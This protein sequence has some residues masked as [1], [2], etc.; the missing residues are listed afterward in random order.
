MLETGLDGV[1]IIEPVV[2]G[3]DRGFFLEN[4]KA[5]S[6]RA[7]GLPA[8]FSQSNVSRSARGVLRGLHFQFRKCQ[9]KL[10]SVFEGCIFDV[11]VDVRRGSTSF[12]QWVGTQLSADN[13]RQL[14]IPA[15]FAHGFL[16]LSEGAL[17][18]YLCTTEY[19]PEYDAAVAWDDPA[20]GVKWPHTP[21]ALSA[22]D[23]NAPLLKD[24]PSERLPYAEI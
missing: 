8:A 4:W 12:G 16:V 23:R 21:T 19:A 7:H 15:G 2:H 11:A 22:R 5:S 17:F 14:Y 9:G 20:I 1:V 24:I 18:H 10:V 3:D 6:N 13:H